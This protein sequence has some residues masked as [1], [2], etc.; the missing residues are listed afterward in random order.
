MPGEL[1]RM[2]SIWRIDGDHETR[3]ATCA[4]TS[5]SKVPTESRTSG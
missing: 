2:A 3:E 1:A 5:I 4:K